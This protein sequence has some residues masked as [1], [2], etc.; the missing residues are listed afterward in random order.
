MTDLDRIATNK[1]YRVAEVLLDKD[2]NWTI[3]YWG[4]HVEQGGLNFIYGN[5]GSTDLNMLTDILNKNLTEYKDKLIKMIK[6]K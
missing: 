1:K 2:G 5:L 6:D 3:H 4:D